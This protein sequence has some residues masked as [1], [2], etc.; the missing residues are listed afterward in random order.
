MQ[1]L[2]FTRSCILPLLVATLIMDLQVH[3]QVTNP[4]ESSNP[5]SPDRTFETPPAPPLSPQQELA[6]FEIMPGYRLEL[7]ASDPL[8]QDPVAMTFDPDGRIWLCEMRGF[9]P[10]IDGNGENEPAGIISVLEDTDSDGLMDKSNV[11]V[12]GLILPRGLCWT[13]DGLLVCENGTIWLC[14]DLDGDLK[15]DE[16]TVVCKYNA[17]NVEHSLNGLMPALDNWIYNAKEGIR[18][19]RIQGNWVRQSNAARGQWGITQDNYGHLLYNVNA[20]LV[21]GD[22]VPCYSPNAQSANPL[23]NVELCQ[24]QEVFPIRPNPGINRGYLPEFLRPDGSIINANSNCGPVVYRGD[25]L[26]EEL[27][28]N[29][30]IP[31]PAGNLVR[32]QVLVEVD[33]KKSSKNAYDRKEFIASTDERFRPVNMVN[34]PDG[35][36]YLLDMYRGIIQHGAFMTPYLRQ[37][38]LD[39]QLDKPINLG[40]IYR[41][42]HEGTANRQPIKMSRLTSEELVKHLSNPNGWHRDMAQQLLVQ[43]N[44]LSVRRSLEELARQGNSSLGRLHAIWTL[45]G[46]NVLDWEVLY[47]LLSDS[48]AHVR[49][50]SVALYRRLVDIEAH[51]Q[52]LT[53]ELADVQN[54]PDAN[55]RMQLIQTLGLMTTPEADEIVE[56]ILRR[57]AD[58]SRLLESYVAGFAGR[59]VEFL[60]ART[61][62]P[63]WSDGEPWRENILRACAQLLWRQRQ[64]LP[65]LK[66]SHLVTSLP[67][68]QSWQQIALLEGIRDPPP[69]VRRTGFR[70]GRRRRGPRLPPTVTLPTAAEGLTKLGKS[71][72]LRLASAAQAFRG[73][74]IWPGKD[75]QSIPRRAKL[76]PEHQRLYDIGQREYMALCAGCHHASGY[77][78][79]AKGPP[80]LESNWLENEERLIRLVL[81]GMRGPIRINGDLYNVDGRLSMPGIYKTLDDEKIAGVLTFVRRDWYDDSTAVEVET[82]SKIRGLMS[83]RTDQWT[84]TELMAAP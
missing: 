46:L 77:G 52:T 26:P 37:Q 80:L 62:S 14:R 29:V 35:T 49:A 56:P 79:A 32:R 40:R 65:L 5:Q 48:N 84:E 82:V 30:F 9:M 12:D 83:G 45:E 69:R 75:G 70:S 53:A 24:D 13:I 64:P 33:G 4:S 22:L 51:A 47:E 11:F 18:L 41:I 6:T 60:Q 27:I 2:R 43:R 19:R 73:K 10:D 23:V 58:D 34:A 72:N 36:L 78:H 42:A 17:G 68:E 28:G 44:D 38:V 8:I 55:V 61:S 7:V 31:E 39:R 59:E 20:S 74:L 81:L 76:S 63:N 54:D 21:R 16:K 15:C 71:S 3:A 67:E 66:L 50:S 1:I 25:N 57:A